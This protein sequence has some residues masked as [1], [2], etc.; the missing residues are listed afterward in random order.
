MYILRYI[1]IY[2]Y[3]KVYKNL[4]EMMS[5]SYDKIQYILSIQIDTSFQK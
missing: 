4:Y 3:P 1:K 2:A 5:L